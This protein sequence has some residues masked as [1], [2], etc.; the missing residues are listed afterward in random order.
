MYFIIIFFVTPSFCQ[1]A[2]TRLKPDVTFGDRNDRF[3]VANI[4]RQQKNSYKDLMLDAQSDEEYRRR[5]KNKNKHIRIETHDKHGN[6]NN[7]DSDTP[8]SKSWFDLLNTKMGR[9]SIRKKIVKKIEDEVSQLANTIITK[10]RSMRRFDDN[11][12]YHDNMDSGGGDV[13]DYNANLKKIDPG[14]KDSRHDEHGV[15]ARRLQRIVDELHGSKPSRRVLSDPEREILL[16]YA[17]PVDVN[18][19]GFLQTP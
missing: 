10:M 1:Y 15:S 12:A 9:K 18:I 13:D 3:D 8:K 6:K 11:F 7:Y 2:E 17:F 19:E 14:F 5:G 4:L 16:H